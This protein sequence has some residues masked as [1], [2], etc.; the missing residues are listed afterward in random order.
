M[1]VYIED[2]FLETTRFA[3]LVD[4]LVLFLSGKV[5][6]NF[7]HLGFHDGGILME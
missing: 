2:S 6:L 1:H 3:Y 5:I 4:Q 7:F